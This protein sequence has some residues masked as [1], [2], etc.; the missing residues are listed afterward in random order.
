MRP[1]VRRHLEHARV[2]RLALLLQEVVVERLQVE[3]ARAEQRAKRSRRAP[4]STKRARHT[5]RRTQAGCA[6]CARPRSSSRRLAP[7]SAHARA[8]R[9]RACRACRAAI[10]LDARVHAPRCSPRAAA[11][12]TRSSS[13]RARACSRSSSAKSLRAWC[14]EVTSPS[15]QATS[16]AR[17]RR[18][19]CATARRA[20]FEVGRIG[21]RGALGHPQHGAARARVC[22][23]L[24]VGRAHRAPDESSAA[25][26]A[27]RWRAA[28]AARAPPAR[29][30]AQEALDDAVLER[31]EADHHEAPAAAQ[32]RRS[33]CGS[34]YR[35]LPQARD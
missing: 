2:A 29:A 34:V 28:A 15:A 1:R 21:A 26:A 19:S 32:A 30:A 12:R 33:A 20:R 35:Q 10:L 16:T 7:T 13:S 4:T 24:V 8:G 17:S 11:G 9:A 23:G 18:F 25:A 14:C 22:F 6:A 3:R 27:S 5:G 31:M